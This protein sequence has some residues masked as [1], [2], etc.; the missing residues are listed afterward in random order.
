MEKLD[1]DETLVVKGQGNY[2][3]ALQLPFVLHE[4]R[5]FEVELDF[6]ATESVLSSK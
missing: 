2:W 4:E 5:S 3:L 1:G 6:D